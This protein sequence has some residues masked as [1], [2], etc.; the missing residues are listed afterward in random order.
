MEDNF[1]T[2]LL[3]EPTRVLLD[4]LS[5][6]GLVGNVMVGGRL[7]YSDHE[8][9]EFLILGKLRREVSRTTTL[10]FQRADF[11][12]FRSLVDRVPWEAVLK[13]KGVQEGW[14]FFKKENLKCAGAGHPHVPK[15]EPMGKK[16]A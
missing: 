3:R 12:L 8:M 5:R 4:L 2:Q 10:D 7:W 15:A 11:G 1:L 9:I 14:T 6:E 13:S 16:T